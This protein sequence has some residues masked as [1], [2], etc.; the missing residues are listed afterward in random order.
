MHELVA[1]FLFLAS[2]DAFLIVALGHYT[3]DHGI[4]NCFVTAEIAVFLGNNGQ[5]AIVAILVAQARGRLNHGGVT[6]L[7]GL[8][9]I[10]VR[11]LNILVEQGKIVDDMMRR[12]T[13]IR[14][15][16]SGGETSSD[17]SLTRG[18]SFGI[19]PSSEDPRYR[20]NVGV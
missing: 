16:S 7:L 15:Q 17:A 12:L 8:R 5:Q 10:H 3:V 4:A 11:G 2:H 13:D 20:R 6:A 19:Q 1:L 18:V 14:L 9:D